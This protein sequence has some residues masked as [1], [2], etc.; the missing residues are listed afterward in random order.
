[1]NFKQNKLPLQTK[2]PLFYLPQLQ[3]S[4]IVPSVFRYPATLGTSSYNMSFCDWHFPFCDKHNV[5]KV[6]HVG[7]HV[8]IF[9]KAEQYSIVHL[10]QIFCIHLSVVGLLGY[11]AFW[12]LWIMVLWT[13]LNKSLLESLL[14][15]LLKI[16]RNRPSRLYGNSILVSLRNYHTVL[17]SD[18]TIWC[19]YKQCTKVFISLHSC[20][21]LL[22]CVF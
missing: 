12:L 10:C 2:L 11:S 16:P 21:H 18:Y 7:A 6:H 22:F 4:S 15:I 8:R 9:F 17:H 1:M 3:A 13:S 19:S 14:L 5:F 20:E